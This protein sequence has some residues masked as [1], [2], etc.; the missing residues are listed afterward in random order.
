M[1]DHCARGRFL[2]GSSRVDGPQ[3]DRG[4]G[5]RAPRVQG[6]RPWPPEATSPVATAPAALASGPVVRRAAGVGCDPAG[7]GRRERAAGPGFLGVGVPALA[8]SAS[9]VAGR[10]ARRRRQSARVAGVP[11]TRGPLA[12]RLE[13]LWKV[14]TG[15]TSVM[16]SGCAV[17]ARRPGGPSVPG[18]AAS[19]TVRPAAALGR[20]GAP[21]R[22]SPAH[23]AANRGRRRRRHA[24]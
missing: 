21:A 10:R 5:A 17:R 13:D 24:K 15:I 22:P 6:R 1:Y 20:D 2:L 18:Q 16:C 3:V 7:P 23:T 11:T 14:L 19:R 4:F 9:W 8:G 12:G